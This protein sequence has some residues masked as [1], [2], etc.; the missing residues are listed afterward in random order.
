[1]GQAF[2]QFLSRQQSSPVEKP[3]CL[4]RC[5][6][7]RQP[8]FRRWKQWQTRRPNVEACLT[9]ANDAHGILHPR[10]D[11][12]PCLIC[13]SKQKVNNWLLCFKVEDFCDSCILNLRMVCFTLIMRSWCLRAVSKSPR[14]NASLNATN[15][16]GMKFI[17]TPTNP[18][19]PAAKL[20]RNLLKQRRLHTKPWLKI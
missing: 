5:L 7:S 19:Q 10:E 12:L 16:R 18:S 4:E 3:E 9:T 6:E 15:S 17:C 1:M 20:I 14:S 13:Y 2:D 8:G 11:V